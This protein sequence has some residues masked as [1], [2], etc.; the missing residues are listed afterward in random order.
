M[1]V[2]TIRITMLVVWELD[3]KIGNEVAPLHSRQK[4]L[5]ETRKWQSSRIVRRCLDVTVQTDVRHRSFARKELL[6]VTAQ[7]RFVF[8]IFRD[9]RKSIV[10]L[11]DRFPVLRR[12]RMT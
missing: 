1:A 11:A 6:P 12:E 8:R 4:T 10:R 9:I 5:T 2:R 3:S 7:T